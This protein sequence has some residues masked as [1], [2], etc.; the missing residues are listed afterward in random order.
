[1]PVTYQIALPWNRSYVP[2]SVFR[3][4]VSLTAAGAIVKAV[5]VL[6][7]VTI[8]GTYG[9]VDAMDAFVAAALIPGLLV[10]LITESLN[11]AF[12]PTLIRVQEQE[13]RES[14]QQLFSNSMFWMCLL[15][16]TASLAMALC[17]RE[18]FPLIASHYTQAKLGLA[19]KMFYALLPLVLITGIAAHCN[20]VLNT[21]DRFAVPALAP[22]LISALTIAAVILFGGQCGIWAVVYGNLAGALIHAL[23]IV[24]MLHE[25]GYKLRLSWARRSPAARE[26]A[27]RYGPVFLSSILASG[28]LLVDQAMAATLPAG[29]VSALAYANR[30]VSV[31]ITLLAGAVSTAIMPHFSRMVVQRNWEQCRRSLRTWLGLTALV[32]VPLTIV[33]IAGAH[34]LI[35]VTLQHGAFG[36]QDTVVVTSVLIMYAVQIPFYVCS[37]VCYRFLLSMLRTDLIFY[38]GALNLVLD[39]VLNL[40]LMRVLGI[41]GI[42]L[43]TSLWN[44]STFLFLLYWSRKLLRR[45]SSEL[46]QTHAVSCLKGGSLK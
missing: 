6:K 19:V 22:M 18:L 9:R 17:G 38:C 1:M 35:R 46:P 33:L 41:A 26:V 30:F 7:E 45:A 40:V 27:S 15:L 29:S 21:L 5:A 4:A 25:H 13:G 28:G 12:V 31:V 23:V 34:G 16:S 11:Q 36:R 10:N 32:S 3:A 24:W 8:A 37:R 39:I 20:A 14:A 2:G 43:A 44:V 42:A